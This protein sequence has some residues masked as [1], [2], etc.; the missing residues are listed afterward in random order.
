MKNLN[1]NRSWILAIGLIL[2][3]CQTP[4]PSL[5]ELGARFEPKNVYRAVD[6]LPGNLQRVVLM[7]VTLS[8]PDLATL[9]HRNQLA[10][11]LEEEL[12]KTHRFE[13][14]KAT[15]EELRRG[16]GKDAFS[17]GEPLPADLLTRIQS[18]HSADGVIFAQL[19]SYRPFPPVAIGWELRLV[20]A[21]QGGTLWSIDETFDASQAEVARS[22]RDYFR[23][24][25]TGASELADPQSDLRSPSRFCRYTAQTVWQ[26][27]PKR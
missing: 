23:G 13:V 25:H 14:I 3:G 27:L 9:D 22:A 7:P 2:A 16:F 18:A 8:T 24:H 10:K 5:P 21:D 15:P 6:V 17:A 1:P 26:T 4:K 19:A 20:T 12:R 11:I